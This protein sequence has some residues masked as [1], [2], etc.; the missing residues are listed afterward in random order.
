MTRIASIIRTISSIVA[1][2]MMTSASATAMQME[3]ATP[4][5]AGV[6]ARPAIMLA[7]TAQKQGPGPAC[8]RCT[9]QCSVCGMGPRC[10]ETCIQHGNGMVQ[11]GP[12]NCSNWFASAGCKQSR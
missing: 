5:P 7:Q 4:I 11:A 10:N 8:H 6:T 3:F 9:A 2:M 1:I 12:G